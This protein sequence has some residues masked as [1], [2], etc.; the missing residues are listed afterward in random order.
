MIAR[1]P[2]FYQ[3]W[4]QTRW[5]DG[6][7][8]E[9]IVRIYRNAISKMGKRFSDQ[10]DIGYTQSRTRE[11]LSQRFSA[12]VEIQRVLPRKIE[13]ALQFLVGEMENMDCRR[14]AAV[15]LARENIGG[16]T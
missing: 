9:G 6:G 4:R 14:C 8:G 15:E 16:K 3:L 10:I 1:H 7:R 13:Y 12:L 11:R 2:R 5:G